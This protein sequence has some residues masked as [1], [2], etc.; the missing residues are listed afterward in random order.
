MTTHQFHRRGHIVIAL[1]LLRQTG[2]L[3]QLFPVSHPLRSK[4]V[5]RSVS[6]APGFGRSSHSSTHTGT[7]ARAP[8]S[9]REQN[10]EQPRTWG[11]ISEPRLE[12]ATVQIDNFRRFY[13]LCLYVATLAVPSQPSLIQVSPRALFF[14]LRFRLCG[15]LLLQA[16]CQSQRT[17]WRGVRARTFCISR[18][19]HFLKIAACP[20]GAHLR[21]EVYCI[22][23]CSGPRRVSA[24][25]NS[26]AFKWRCMKGW[27][28]NNGMRGHASVQWLPT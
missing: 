20:A 21:T 2:S 6:V 17:G 9:K 5:S 12:G 4:T 28:N 24:I 15:A 14:P 18:W 27:W 8:V 16:S 26:S 10:L 11:W 19:R 3:D 25:R 7:R 23:R 13:R 1:R 22:V